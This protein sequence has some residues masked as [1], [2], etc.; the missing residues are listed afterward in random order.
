MNNFAQIND[1]KYLK[2]LRKNPVEIILKACKALPL[3][4]WRNVEI[5]CTT[6]FYSVMCQLG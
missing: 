5:S 6:A 1:K 2:H 4:H 3:F